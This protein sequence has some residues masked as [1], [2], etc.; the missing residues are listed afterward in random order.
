MKLLVTLKKSI[1]VLKKNNQ[2]FPCIRQTI[3]LGKMYFN[4]K[5]FGNIPRVTVRLFLGNSFYLFMS[6]GLRRK[7]SCYHW[8]GQTCKPTNKYVFV[9]QHGT[10]GCLMDE[11]QG[12]LVE[13]IC[14]DDVF[15]GKVPG[16]M[17]AWRAEM[18][19][20]SKNAYLFNQSKYKQRLRNIGSSFSTT[21]NAFLSQ[22]R[23]NLHSH[24]YQKRFKI[25]TSPS[26]YLRKSLRS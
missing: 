10:A 11:A 2:L 6:L 9:K 12:G 17:Q 22:H 8:S 18:D 15:S 5:L 4:H 26:K 20:K 16:S 23:T 19:E 24:Q 3:F 25:N 1:A 7:Q 13:K 14:F 21:E